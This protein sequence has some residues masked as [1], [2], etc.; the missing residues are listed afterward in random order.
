[1]KAY[2]TE[3]SHQCNY[4]IVTPLCFHNFIT[5]LCEIFATTCCLYSNSHIWKLIQPSVAKIVQSAVLNFHNYNI[6]NQKVN[7]AL[8]R[9]ANDCC[10]DATRGGS[11]IVN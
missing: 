10:I 4:V 1:M 2:A 8:I 6:M 11:T 9:N 7:R 5:A 3:F